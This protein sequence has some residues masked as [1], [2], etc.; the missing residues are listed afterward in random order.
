MPIITTYGLTG[1][2][3]VDG[4]LSG[5]KWGVSSL[6]FSFPTSASYYGSNYGWDEPLDNFEAFNTTQQGAVRAILQNYSTVAN[7]TF[8]EVNE[9]STVHGDLRYAKSDAPGTAWAYYPST[10]AEGGDAWF[11]NSSNA[12]DSPIKGN[13]ASFSI[14]HETGHA[15]GLKHPQDTSDPFGTMPA[16][17]NSVEYS[18]MSYRS[19]VGANANYYTNGAY[20]YPQTLMMYDIA[21]LQ[22]LYGANYSTNNGDTVYSWS[23]STGEQFINGFGQGAPGGNK[24]FM[25]LWDGG[26]HDTYDFSNYSSNLTIDLRPGYWTTVSTTQL[27]SLGGGHVATGNIAN[28]LL[29]QNNA[30][31]LIEDAIGGL[32]NDTIIGNDADN[33]LTGGAGNDVLDGGAGN[34]IAAFS[35]AISNYQIV[36]N[37]NGTW[38]ITDLRGGSPD[39]VDTLSNIELVQFS[40]TTLSLDIQ[41][42]TLVSFSTDSGT[43]GD[44]IT[45]DNT[46]TL[47]GT[48][49]ANSTIKVYDSGTF[50]DFVIA[51][52]NGNW[53]FTTL[54]LVNGTHG[55]TAT[56]TSS[57]GNTS[58]VSAVLNV[59]IDTVAPV[60]NDDVA[61]TDKNVSI[62]I[63]VLANDSDSF[64]F[65]LSIFG[66]PTALHGTVTVNPNETLR[67]TPNSNYIGSDTITYLVGDGAQAATGQVAVTVMDTGVNL[68]GTADADHLV[69]TALADTLQG[70]DGDDLLDGGAGADI[71]IGGKGNDT[72]VVDNAGDV[73][74]EVSTPAYSPPAGFTIKGTADLNGD[75]ELDV[76]LVNAAGSVTELQLIKNGVGQTPVLLPSWA[77]WSLQ[78]FADLNGDGKKDVFYQNGSSQYA[79][80]LNGTSQTGASYVSGKTADAVVALSGGNQGTDT[81]QS[82]IS[83]TLPGGVENLTL[84]GSANIDGTGNAADNVLIGNTGNN[85]ITGGAGV[86][87]LTGGL[88]VD[89]FVFGPGDTGTTAGQRDLITDFTPGTDKLDI[90]AID[91]NSGTTANDAFRF[92]GSAA[93]DGEAGALHTRYEAAGNLTV[94]EADRNGDGVA[95]FA[96]A[97]SGNLTLSTADFT[98]ASIILPVNASGVAGADHLVGSVV[99]DT[100]FGMGGDDT[101]EGLDGDDLLDG[102]AGADI[103]IGGKGNDTYVVDNAGDVVTEVSTPAYSPPAGF[104]IKGTADLNGDGELDVLLV[105]AAGSVTELQLIKNGVGQTPVLLPSWAGWS[106]QGFADLNGDGKKDVFYQNG[107]SQYA[108]FLNGTSQTGASYVSGKTADAVVAL[109][110]GNQGTDT[111]Q[112]SISY[113]LPGGVENL[114]LTGSANIDGTGNAADNVLIGNT[115]N[116]VITGGAGVDTL[117]GGLGVDTFVFG[118]GD[119]GTTAGQRDL[120]TDFTPGTD[121]L[122]IAAIDANSG[123][124]ANDAFRFLGS[125][126]FDGEAGAL[127]TRYEAAGNLTVL[128]ADRNGDGVAD[129]AIAMSGNLTLSTADFTTAS[130]ILPVNASGVAGADHLVG[131]V[132]NDTLFGMGGDDTLEG[133]DGDDLLDGGAGADI[134]IGGKGNDTYVVDN[135]GDVV[136][137]V[138]TPAYSPPAGF[139]IKGTADLNGDGELDVLLVN[140]AGSVTELQLIKNGVGQAP[141]LLPSWAGWS[142]QGFADLNGDGKKDVFYQNGSSQYA[143]F[144][145][146]TS[147]TGASYVSGKTAD[148]VVA[149]SGGNQGTD[150]VQSSISYTLPGGVENLTLTGSANIDGTGNAA[151][152]VLIGNTGNNVITGGA[153]VDTLTGGLGVDTFVFGPGDTG[154]TAGQRDLI[155]DFTPGTDKLDIAA[156]DANSGTTANDAFRFLGS[157]AFDGEAGALHTRYEAAGNLTV[158]EADRNGDG[159][160]DFAIAMSGN[161][162]LSTA[163]FTTASIILPVNASG[164][165]GADHLVGSVVNDTLFGMGGDDTL[166]GLDGDDLLDGG[167]GADIMIG[168]KG[169]DTYVVDNAGDVVT[170][171]STPAYSPPAGFTIKGTAD[172]NG[173]GELDVLLVNAAGSVTELQLIKNG[174]GQSPVLLPS[175]AGWSLQ[176]FADLNGDG[177]KDVFYQ[178][179]SSQY[180]VFLNGTSQTGASYVSGKT[181][182]AVVALSGGNQG[183]DTVQSSI[184]YTLPGGVENLTL[185]GSANIDGT[186][187]AADNVLIG[188]TGN[189]V[190][191]G[192]AGVDTLTGGL[193]VDTFVFGP[194]DTGTTAGQ[195]DLITD[196]T[197][198]TDKLDIAAIDANSG[199]TANDAFR[200]L[201]SAAFDGEAGALHTRYEAAG[202]LTV[203]EADRNGDG[204]ADFAIAMSGNL[205]LSTADFTTA[206]IILPASAPPAAGAPY[207]LDGSPADGGS[208]DQGNDSSVPTPQPVDSW[209]PQHWDI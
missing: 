197:P 45:S 124:T 4:V 54:A 204:V 205:T 66:T 30:A 182:D 36:K 174:V 100:L 38:T 119:T 111:V 83:Y 69:G 75:G 184:S 147:Q 26:G 94:L 154:T 118:P 134:M 65:G 145:N 115:G 46:L 121:K 113:T 67:Y 42:P 114:T 47:T 6:T 39:G 81:V 151:D 135:A 56:A 200:F 191:T 29:Y 127:H 209:H 149:L 11:Q 72:Y 181:A 180:A 74:T 138:S 1:D 5:V 9:T 12:Y 178:N 25:T 109:S 57:A 87:T 32:G 3:Y 70:L 15:L 85:V 122:D 158:L 78:G 187:N 150:T 41:A 96:I 71:M 131:S 171:V 192:G 33:K 162:T 55:F 106:L 53:S 16:D 125:A 80:F 189:N 190:I 208:E 49:E 84:T 140:A 93:F 18:V 152:N 176:G 143:V 183:T 163:D 168:G 153:G 141:V 165:A 186:G 104:T 50:L 156:I 44:H 62:N 37:A 137:E 63:D 160:A 105:N 23:A 112:S 21:A 27:A 8:T 58:V 117:T 144:L 77:G 177:K 129:F 108:V 146:G 88:G 172:L 20:N 61:T 120:I 48:A 59:T 196:F 126:A 92:L 24:I 73:V 167:A 101:L 68:I 110:G 7:V 206:S 34:D 13:Y 157:A 116:N 202:N 136:T 185:T 170:E 133:L 201:G 198:G 173:D 159:V 102:G 166:E 175:W 155:T 188:N 132:V 139:T 95:D 64:G 148:A 207:G 107:S 128:E 31:S 10:S 82:S 169:N 14:I 60:A 76:L 35:G 52:G 103:M 17:R 43:P 195:R 130:I 142:L 203:L 199:T 164:V 97:M 99:N 79:V 193:G 179:G 19:Y 22:A 40:N 161:L 2:P 194:G 90:A 51:D 98:T 28:S 123:T 91:A 89:T 86:D